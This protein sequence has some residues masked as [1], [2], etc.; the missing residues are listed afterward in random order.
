LLLKE[1]RVDSACN[2]GRLGRKQHA[3]TE[4]CANKSYSHGLDKLAK[5]NADR[6]RGD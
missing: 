1:A 6:D 3:A 5:C 4:R 2:Y